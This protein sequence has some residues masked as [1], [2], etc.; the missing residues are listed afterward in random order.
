MKMTHA[1]HVEHR[2][3]REAAIQ[4]KKYQSQEPWDVRVIKL[5]MLYPKHYIACLGMQQSNQAAREAT[6]HYFRSFMMGEILKVIDFG[7]YTPYRVTLLLRAVRS[8]K[9]QMDRELL[10]R[11]RKQ[12]A[13]DTPT[14]Q[15]H[16]GQMG[17]PSYK[18]ITTGS[19]PR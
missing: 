13:E 17:S 5:Q 8:H 15:S 6:H 9:R 2:R 1:E 18:V 14:A 7:V 10:A 12:Q 19:G 4:T 16:R 3:I 11:E